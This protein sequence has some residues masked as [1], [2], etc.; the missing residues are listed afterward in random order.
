M[1]RYFIEPAAIQDHSAVLQDGDFHHAKHVMRMQPNDEVTICDNRG[2]IAFCH[3]EA[4]L[5][6]KIQLTIDKKE[7]VAPSSTRFVVAQALIKKDAFETMLQKAT[8]LGVDEII[9]VAFS[10]SIVKLDASDEAKKIERYQSIVKEAS[11]QSERAFLPRIHP[12]AKLSQ[13][14]Y[15]IY[16]LI[17]VA[18]A[19]ADLKLRFT[20]ALVGADL[21]QPVLI[22][23]GPEGG[24]ADQELELLEHHGGKL[25]SFGN[26]IL[27]SETASLYALSILHYLAEQQR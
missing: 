10:R 14:D 18:H 9:P 4:I 6:D 19:R 7:S 17:L 27:R 12:V 2:L 20:D 15:S 24:I 25:V 26:R 13:I 21:R 16:S 11:E 1:Q 3:V 8:E 22:V 5:K 23:I